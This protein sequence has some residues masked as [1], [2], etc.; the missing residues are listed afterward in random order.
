VPTGVLE[1]SPFPGIVPVLS[2][3][4]RGASLQF[5][6]LK[7]ACLTTRNPPPNISPGTG[8]RITYY[9]G[10]DVACGIHCVYYR[11]ELQEIGNPDLVEGLADI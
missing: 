7:A 9:G 1:V 3:L 8:D 11:Y 6:P 4:A 2:R 5:A 10:L